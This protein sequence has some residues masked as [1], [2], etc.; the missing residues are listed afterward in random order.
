M[1]WVQ[2]SLLDLKTIISFTHLMHEDLS[3][4]IEVKV[5]MCLPKKRLAYLVLLKSLFHV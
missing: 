1:I 5:K 2:S 4:G 3:L